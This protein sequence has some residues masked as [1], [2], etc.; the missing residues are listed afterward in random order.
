MAY[1]AENKTLFLAK[2]PKHFKILYD[3][4]KNRI[5]LFASKLNTP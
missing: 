4:N 3:D 1:N 2:L 5:V